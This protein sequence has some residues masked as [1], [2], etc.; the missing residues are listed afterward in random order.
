MCEVIKDTGNSRR[1][2]KHG[3]QLS[4]FVQRPGEKHMR[5]V[6]HVLKHLSGTYTD[7]IY[8]GKDSQ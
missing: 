6:E 5:A 4:Q 2:I 3:G 7:G 1:K 8:Y